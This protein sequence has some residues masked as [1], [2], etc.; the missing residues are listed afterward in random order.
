V[1]PSLCR[2][3]VALTSFGKEKRN[4]VGFFSTALLQERLDATGTLGTQGGLLIYTPALG[5]AMCPPGIGQSAG[6]LIYMH[7]LG[8][9][10]H[11]IQASACAVA[12]FMAMVD[13]RPA[14]SFRR[15]LPTGENGH[16][17]SG[18]PSSSRETSYSLISLLLH[19]VI[20]EVLLVR[21][22]LKKGISHSSWCHTQA[23]IAELWKLRHW[24]LTWVHGVVVIVIVNL[25]GSGTTEETTSGHAY[26]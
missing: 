18:H 12:L 24:C 25:T 3:S 5:R 15:Q 11:Q 22:S 1:V 9:G 23:S 6:T 4:T 21:V 8:R 19:Q 14:P 26:E 10:W 2:E 17:Y 13:Q 16:K 7:P 20:S